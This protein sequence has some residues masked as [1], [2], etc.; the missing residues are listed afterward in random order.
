MLVTEEVQP[1]FC[2]AEGQASEELLNFELGLHIA[3][4][5]NP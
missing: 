3:M 5:S 2:W 4:Q 1:S